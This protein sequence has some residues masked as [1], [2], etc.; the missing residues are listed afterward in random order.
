MLSNLLCRLLGPVTNTPQMFVRS[1]CV[2]VHLV[3][4]AKSFSTGSGDPPKFPLNGYVR[5]LLQ[6]RPV[7]VKQYPGITFVDVSRK[8]AQQW[9]SLTPQQKQPFENTAQ[10]AMDKYKEELKHFHARLTPEQFDA[11]LKM[12]QQK[13]VTRKN[14]SLKRELTRLGKPKRPRSASNI[15]LSERMSLTGGTTMQAKLSSLMSDWKKLDDAQKKTYRQLA[16]DDKVRYTHE[17]KAWEKN[18]VEIGRED[19]VRSKDKSKKT[20]VKRLP[21]RTSP[22]QKNKKA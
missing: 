13:L 22:A 19:L 10:A 14:L 7:I 9:Q 16:E 8:I 11:L 20:K 3:P 21:R 12:K 15:F 18:M 6:Q 17:I 4:V 5:F 1:P 2:H